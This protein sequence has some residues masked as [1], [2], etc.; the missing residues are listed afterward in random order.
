MF[1]AWFL[2]AAIRRLQ[3]VIRL[4]EKPYVVDIPFAAVA[5]PG[6]V[7][8]LFGTVIAVDRALLWVGSLLT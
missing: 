1:W 7:I 3:F 4:E 6:F 8:V 5:W 2:S